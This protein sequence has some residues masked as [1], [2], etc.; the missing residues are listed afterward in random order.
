MSRYTPG[1][2]H[3]YKNRNGEYTIW[4]D[5]KPGAV[6]IADV[7]REGIDDPEANARLMANAPELF[8]AVKLM[9]EGYKATRAFLK[10]MK[11]DTSA[12]DGIITNAGELIDKVD[13]RSN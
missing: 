12:I 3:W 9:N 1:T 6:K 10:H 8:E 7:N 11:F 4:P 13:G 2:W 5:G